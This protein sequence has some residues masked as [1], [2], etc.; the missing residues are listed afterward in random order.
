VNEDSRRAKRVKSRWFSWM[1]V[2]RKYF[3]EIEDR[4]GARESGE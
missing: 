2:S 4:S 1:D 3:D